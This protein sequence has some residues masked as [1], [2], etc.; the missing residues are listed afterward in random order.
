MWFHLSSVNVELCEF[1]K[2]L[3]NP[4]NL[5]I[6]LHTEVKETS[7]T[8]SLVVVQGWAEA[9]FSPNVSVLLTTFK[10]GGWSSSP[11][12]T[13]KTDQWGLHNP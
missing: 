8:V 1:L 10:Y 6:S 7:Q 4:L 2:L 12:G 3:V 9:E 13:L 5:D 11:T